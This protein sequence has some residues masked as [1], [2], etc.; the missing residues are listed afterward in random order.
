MQSK[1]TVKIKSG[2]EGGKR[3]LNKIALFISGGRRARIRSILLAMVVIIGVQYIFLNFSRK[4]SCAEG[5]SQDMQLRVNGNTEPLREKG[6]SG[7]RCIGGDQAMLFVFDTPGLY[8][9]WMKDMNFAIDVVWLDENRSVVSVEQHMR[10]SSY[11]RVYQPGMQAKYVVELQD[12]ASET[13]KI[14]TGS[15][16]SW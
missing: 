6:L 11:P 2:L 12:G 7:R 14:S 15:A 9:I 5:P 16:F 10:P 13:A 1:K 4:S 3:V 8:G